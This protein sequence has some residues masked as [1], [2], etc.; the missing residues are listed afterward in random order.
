MSIQEIVED[1]F[2]NFDDYELSE[3]FENLEDVEISLEIWENHCAV[4][5]NL[6]DIEREVAYQRKHRRFNVVE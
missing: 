2:E 4:E 6:V 5:Q 3:M 1:Y